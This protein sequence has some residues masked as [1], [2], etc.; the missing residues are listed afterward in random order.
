LEGDIEPTSLAQALQGYRQQAVPQELPTP[1]DLQWKIEL[2]NG[3]VITI[4]RPIT[5]TTYVWTVPNQAGEFKIAA[6]VG[7]QPHGEGRLSITA[8]LSDTAAL[9]STASLT[10]TASV[11]TTA[12]ATTTVAAE[13]CL[14]SSFVADVTIPDGTKLKNA[15]TFTKT[16]RI[17]NNGQCNWPDDT[18]LVF[19]SGTKLG[20]PD[21]VQVGA[22]VSGTQKD[23]SVQLKAPDQY[24]N[25]TG[26][27]Q[28]KSAQGNF[29][30]QMSAVI[31]AG[32]PPA[33]GNVVAGGN[34]PP[35]QPVSLGG[36]ELGGQVNCYPS[37]PALMRRA[38]M[39]WVKIQVGKGCGLPIADMHNL[40]F[41]VLVSAVSGDHSQ[42]NDEA[43]QNKFAAD[44]ASYAAQGA[45]AIEVW[46]EMN[47]DQEWPVGTINAASYVRMLQKAYPAI[48]AANPNTIVIS[49]A[50]APTGFFG[51]CGAN[52]CDD[53]PYVAS[54]FAS[55]AANYVDCIGVHYNEGIVPPTQTSG[56]PRSDHYTRYFWGM[57]N[58][59][60]NASGGSRKLCFTELGYLTPEGMGGGPLGP[61]FGWAQ[62]TT[63]AQQAQWLASAASLAASSGKVRLMIVWNAD[64]KDYN[65]NGDPKGGYAIIRPGDSCPACDALGAVVGSR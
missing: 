38:G 15:E 19:V 17:N 40:G 1:F 54:M 61:G 3:Q 7:S 25:Y 5:D 9:S 6:L 62:N 57:V 20:S 42:A 24:G 60:W 32:D 50:P 46:N 55:G 16:W 39:T 35:A 56:D 11:T 18:T 34:P 23:I 45:D 28:L 44:L 47:I 29:G 36:F 58:A 27:W 4:T 8:A 63:V 37:N 13:L 49:G 59:Y 2:A 33:G 22:V 41:K 52:G 30:T 26:L 51:G 31:V 14:S 21:S 48:K 53:A 12:V 65:P 10:T 43:F 64:F